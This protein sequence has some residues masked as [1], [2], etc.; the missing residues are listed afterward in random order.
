[1]NFTF[2]SVPISIFVSYDRFSKDFISLYATVGQPKLSYQ[3]FFFLA[4]DRNNIA[5]V[6]IFELRTKLS[7]RS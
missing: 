1:M 5:D 6:R 3:Q 2:T 4:V 7:R